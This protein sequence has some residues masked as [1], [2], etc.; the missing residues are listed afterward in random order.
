M[1]LVS[2]LKLNSALVQIYVVGFICFCCPGMFNALNGLGGA[3]QVDPTVANN[4]NV[5]LYACFAVTGTFAGAVFNL[6]GPKVLMTGGG[7]TYSFYAIAQYAAGNSTHFDWMAILSGAL[8]GVGAGLLW[9]AQGALMLAYPTE[10]RK[11]TYISIFW[12]TFNMGG[13]FGGLLTFGI[14][15]HNESGNVSAGTYFTFCAIMALGALLA[16]VLLQ[17]PRDVIK[18]NGERVVIL[19]KAQTPVQEV[20]SLLEL[21]LNKHMLLLIPLFVSSNWFYTYQFTAVNG[22]LFTARARGLNSAL[23]WGSQMVA[24]FLIGKF[25]DSPRFGRRQRAL[26]GLGLV[27]TI[28]TTAWIL[29]YVLQRNYERGELPSDPKYTQNTIDYTHSSYGFP[30][31]VFILYGFSDAMV[32]CYAYWLMGSLTNDLSVASRYTGFYKGMQSSGAAVAWRVDTLNTSFMNQLI[33]NWV[34]F[35]ASVPFASFVA[36]DVQEKTIEVDDDNLSPTADKDEI[37]KEVESGKSYQ[38]A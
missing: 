11:G 15:L 14:N 30:L 7:L 1:D 36:R 28:M 19:H 8:L 32:Q 3:G 25:L 27:T 38:L 21:F 24:A 13:L 5:A 18:E 35:S 2:K 33:I 6:L 20:R 34:L 9:T 22:Y 37:R 16:L 23:Y 4:S 12:F 29:G 31:V 10:E 26:L 17:N